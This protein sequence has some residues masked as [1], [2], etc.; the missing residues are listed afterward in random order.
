MRLYLFVVLI[1]IFLISDVE[2]RFICF[3]DF[4]IPPL[5]KYLSPLPIFLNLIFLL[6][7]CRISLHILDISPLSD[8]LLAIIFCYSVGSL[9]TLLILSFDFIEAFNFNVVQFV[10]FYFVG[11]FLVSFQ[12]IL[13]KS[14][15]MLFF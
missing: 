11:L 3:L 8:I 5:E 2:H 14:T 13:V 12:E 6:L 1:C 10:Y 4:Y 7:S 9:F 15:V